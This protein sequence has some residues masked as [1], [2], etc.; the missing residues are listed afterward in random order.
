[1]LGIVFALLF[2]AATAILVIGVAAKIRTYARVPAPLKIPT[3]PAPKTGFGVVLRMAREVIFFESLFKSNK[4]IWVFAWMFHMALWLVL[5]RHLRYFTQPVWWW[6]QLA[7]PFGTYAA[8]AMI[9]GLA[10]LWARRVLVERIR[11]ISNP[12]DHLMLALLVGI[13]ASGAATR[14]V[15]HTDIVAVK[16]YMLGLMRLS[17]GDLPADPILLVHL[18]LVAVLMIVFPISKLLHAPGVFFS[19]SRNQ[20]DNPREKRHLA[21]WAA[22]LEG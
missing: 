2:Y 18:F 19:P 9:A 6:V 7:Q 20:I 22:K 4:W 8:F 13:G 21:P 1:M 10:G 3:T 15:A 17:V 5:I 12:S 16:T 14:F 11:Y